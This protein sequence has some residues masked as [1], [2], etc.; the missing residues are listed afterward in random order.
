MTSK[1][2][3]YQTMAQ[4]C[5]NRAT[6]ELDPV[7]RAQFFAAAREWQRLGTEAR[8]LAGQ[9]EQLGQ[10]IAAFEAARLRASRAIRCPE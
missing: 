6:H 10:D 4:E 3:A 9:W 8:L 5:V 1:S 2:E 7:V